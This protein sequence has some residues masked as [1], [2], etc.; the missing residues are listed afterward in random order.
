M[1]VLALDPQGVTVLV[2]DGQPLWR[3]AVARAIAQDPA[4]ALVA[5]VADGDA[6][7]AAIRAL[8]PDVAVLDPRLPGIDG[9]AVLRALRAEGS[10]TRVV[11]LADDARATWSAL[12]DGAGGYLARDATADQL[13]RAV[14]AVAAGRTVL[15]PAAQ[16]A[17]AGEIRRRARDDRPLLSARETEVLR[18]IADGRTMPEIARELSLATTTVKTHVL[19]VYERLEVSDRAAAVAV[20]M[21]RGLLE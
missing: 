2:A 12:A 4:L 18:R 9:I 8:R 6:A 13:R 3:D 19:H 1:A 11:F 16:D 14:A 21:R 20:A 17:I 7:I 15:A 10:P 5:E